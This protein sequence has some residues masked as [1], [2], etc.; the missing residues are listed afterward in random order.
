[1]D[2]SPPNLQPPP[3]PAGGRATSLPARLLNVFA[4]PG[5]VFNEVKS[6]PFRAGNWLVPVLLAAI[7]G[8]VSSFIIFSQPAILQKLR[9]QQSQTFDA[10]VKAGK[11]TQAQADKSLA[12]LDKFMGPKTMKIFGTVGAVIG[13]FVRLFWWS[14]VLW[15]LA[16][17]FLKVKLPYVKLMEVVGLASM[18]TIL[19]LIVT[20]LLTVNFGKLM[21]TPSLALAIT[22]FDVHNKSHL[23]LGIL[24]VFTFWFLGVVASGLSRLSGAPFARALLL[25]GFYWLLSELFLVFIGLGQMAL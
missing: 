3:S 19:G 22:D 16:L 18:I 20:L 15:L 14:L 8:A 5:D 7:I 21:S 1:M 2:Q 11:I 4:V 17:F 25:V 6:A 24:N 13:S 10:Q 23:L 12:I 9:E